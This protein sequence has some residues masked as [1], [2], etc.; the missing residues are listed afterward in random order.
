MLA[1]AEF[2]A[3]ILI[4]GLCRRRRG[5]VP[6]RHHDARRRFRRRC[7]RACCNTRRSARGSASSLLL[8]LLLVGGS[9]VLPSASRLRPAVPMRLTAISNTRQIG[10]LLYTRY[11]F[12]FQGAA[13]I[14][15]GRDDRRHRSDGCGTRRTSS[16][17]DGV[18]TDRRKRREAVELVKVKSGQGLLDAAPSNRYRRWPL[19]GGWRGSLHAGRVRHLPQPQE[20]HRH[21][22]VG[23]TDPAGG[24][25]S[26]SSPSRAS[27]AIS[28]ARSSRC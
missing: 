9:F 16:G 6:V 13:A 11:V 20:H 8:E 24:R 14:S 18:Q 22:D 4:V 3:L 2:L 1:G 23:G 28:P 12:L 25:T 7:A 21:P 10:Q 19:S 5:A 17:R 15:A 26:T 27:S